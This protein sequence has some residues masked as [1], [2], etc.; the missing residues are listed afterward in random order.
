MSSLPTRECRQK[1]ART[2]RSI[3]IECAPSLRMTLRNA[4]HPSALTSPATNV[5][6]PAPIGAARSGFSVRTHPALTR[7]QPQRGRDQN[8]DRDRSGDRNPL[9]RGEGKSSQAQRLVEGTDAL[10]VV[11]GSQNARHPAITRPVVRHR[12]AAMKRTACD[13]CERED[14]KHDH[15]T[16]ARPTPPPSSARHQRTMHSH[17]ANSDICRHR[18]GESARSAA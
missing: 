14:R 8:A 12:P 2:S 13:I 1:S 16:R 7:P 5:P 6:P 3:S 9:R 10:R 11:L 18:P 17:A 15:P 4:G